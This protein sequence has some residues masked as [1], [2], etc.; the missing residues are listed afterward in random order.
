MGEIHRLA[1]TRTVLLISHRLANAAGADRIYVL[2]NGR[3]A[4]QGR[5][6]ELLAAGGLY[7]RLWNTQQELE[8]EGEKEAACL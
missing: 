1:R 5:H 3:V 8:H 2:E 4:Q 6:A 7:A